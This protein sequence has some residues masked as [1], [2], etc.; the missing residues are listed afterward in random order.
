M[1]LRRKKQ[2]TRIY[3]IVQRRKKGFCA[4]TNCI[5]ED[6]RQQEFMLKLYAK[7]KK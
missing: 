6:M 5:D 2:K 3:F 7:T 4:C 1:T